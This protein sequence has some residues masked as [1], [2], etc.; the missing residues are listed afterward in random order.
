MNFIKIQTKEIDNKMRGIG[1]TPMPV[2]IPQGTFT[3]TTLIT[4]NDL[5]P[6]TT[7]QNNSG[8]GLVYIQN[9]GVMLTNP[10]PSF[11]TIP[12][13]DIPFLK[14]YKKSG[15]EK[16]LEMQEKFYNLIKCCCQVQ[17][18]EVKSRGDLIKLLFNNYSEAKIESTEVGLLKDLLKGMFSIKKAN[19]IDNT[20]KKYYKRQNKFVTYRLYRENYFEIVGDILQVLESDEV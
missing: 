17:L 18:E 11:E 6:T 9:Q 15:R 20:L 1:L 14:H 7:R 2:M 3:L 12:E 10:E 19:T 13:S 16:W 5:P 8:A 4:D